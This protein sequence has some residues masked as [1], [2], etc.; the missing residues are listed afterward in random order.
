MRN[1]ALLCLCMFLS[2]CAMS[3]PE[4]KMQEDAVVL[5]LEAD[6]QL[7][8]SD[9]KSHALRFVIYQLDN[10]NAFNQ[11]TEDE[12]GLKQLLQSTVFD[13][14]VQVVE[15]M[16]VYPGSDVS[17]RINRAEDARYIAVVAGYQ[18]LMKDRIVQVY[19]IPV[20]VK[21]TLLFFNRRLVPAEIDINLTL[22]PQQIE[23]QEE[24]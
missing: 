15:D 6:H 18:G 14:S 12:E 2:S 9:G 17:Y 3:P 10:P 11:L 23:K 24:E 5:N 1:F 13:P 22:G 16:V 19:E 20:Y 4:W 8:Y 7:N 21:R